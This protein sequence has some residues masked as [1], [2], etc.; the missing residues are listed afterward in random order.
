M[1]LTVTIDTDNAAFDEDPV[2]EVACILEA[3][4]NRFR[5]DRKESPGQFIGHPAEDW[6]GNR[7]GY[8]AWSHE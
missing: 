6:N 1:R 5:R 7:V 4:A 3:L 8:A 2:G